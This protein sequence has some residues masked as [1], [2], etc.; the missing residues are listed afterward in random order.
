MKSTVFWN[1]TSLHFYKIT[2]RHIQEDSHALRSARYLMLVSYLAYS[3][4]LKM[5]TKY[6]SETS[7][8]F[9]LTTRSYMPEERTLL[10]N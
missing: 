3:S 7:V 1:V 9:Q 6:S 10:Y 2:W 8:D 5:E 4:T